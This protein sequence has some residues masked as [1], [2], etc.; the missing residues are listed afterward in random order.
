MTNLFDAGP[1]GRI[2][3]QIKR[4]EMQVDVLKNLRVSESRKRAEALDESQQLRRR[5][6]ALERDSEGLNQVRNGADGV[7]K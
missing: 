4:L 3:F 7:A 2:S 6:G 5:L 1:S